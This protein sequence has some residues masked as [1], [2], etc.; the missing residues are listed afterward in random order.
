MKKER[1]V[2]T[3]VQRAYNRGYAAGN[4]RA[5][6]EAEI[7]EVVV[8]NYVVPADEQCIRFSH[9]LRLKLH[10]DLKYDTSRSTVELFREFT[11]DREFQRRWDKQP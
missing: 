1:Y 8:S 3:D 10:E 11:D 5:K 9:W 4:H 2:T 7:K 6:R